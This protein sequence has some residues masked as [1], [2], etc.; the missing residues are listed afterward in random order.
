LA[1]HLI[2]WDG[3]CGLCRRAVAWVRR[4]DREGRFHAVA[5]QDAP[6]SLMTP[7]MRAAC[8]RAVHVIT[9][10]GQVLRAGRASLFVL[11]ELGFRYTAGVLGWP[12]FVWITEGAYRLVASN[13]RFFSRFLFTRD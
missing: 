5:Y 10:D 11:G 9:S 7:E 6:A 13:R 12:P 1:S 4:R 8:A 2:L 3:T